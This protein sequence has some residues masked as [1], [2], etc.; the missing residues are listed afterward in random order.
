MSIFAIIVGVCLVG[1][2][3]IFIAG[4]RL[5]QV[6]TRVGDQR[7]AAE[8][9]ASLA[10]IHQDS[11]RRLAREVAAGQGDPLALE[12][13]RLIQKILRDGRGAGYEHRDIVRLGEIRRLQNRPQ[14]N[15][16]G[17]KRKPL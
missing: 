12:E 13:V 9:E 8:Q 14:F 7:T 15:L 6:F 2:A 5:F 3:L 17:L 4:L 11:E 16:T 10:E 1:P